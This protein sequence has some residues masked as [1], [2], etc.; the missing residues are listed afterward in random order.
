MEKFIRMLDDFR[1]DASIAHI[2]GFRP[3]LSGV[4][5]WFG[6]QFFMLEDEAWPTCA[7][8]ELAPVLQIRVSE[9]PS[10]PEQLADI[11]LLTL[12]AN[13]EL[14]STEN[15]SENGD[16]WLIRSYSGIDGLVSKRPHNEIEYAPRPF[17]IRWQ[18]RPAEGPGWS[19]IGRL[20][21]YD[22][23]MKD[24]EFFEKCL[25]RYDASS[26]TKVGGW[27]PYIQEGPG[28]VEGDFVFQ[29]S[30]EEKP[31]WMLADNGRMYFFRK[32]GEWKMHWD[33]Y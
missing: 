8:L 20:I 26:S 11:T 27:P 28:N 10:I 17:Q 2:G 5:S 21:N 24:D 7:G 30:S 3:D 25:E 23:I 18:A 1:K 32:E 12:F 31:R 19:D 9:L 33:C 22:D 15:P 6:G 4:H 29:V 16:G 13:P 14:L